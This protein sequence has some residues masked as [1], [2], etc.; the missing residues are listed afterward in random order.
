MSK[1]FRVFFVLFALICS[2]ARADTQNL[3]KYRVYVSKVDDEFHCIALSNGIICHVIPKK[4]G[5]EKFLVAGDEIL[6]LPSVRHPERK[7][8]LKDEGALFLVSFGNQGKAINVWLEESN[9]QM[10]TYASESSVCIKPAGWFSSEQHLSVFELSDGSKWR[11]EDP[12]FQDTVQLFAKEGDRIII[13]HSPSADHWILINIDRLRY[14]KGDSKETIGL[15][16]F[17]WVIPYSE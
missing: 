17:I 4:W 5:S 6:I 8:S 10:L 11:V 15:Y 7:G 1:L 12:A 14:F 9:P 3:D 16:S 13:S 2:L